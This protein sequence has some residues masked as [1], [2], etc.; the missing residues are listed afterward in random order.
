[1]I[2]VQLLDLSDTTDEL[3]RGGAATHHDE[4]GGNVVVKIDVVD[5]DRRALVL[6]FVSLIGLRS[7]NLFIKVLYTLGYVLLFYFGAQ[8]FLHF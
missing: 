7:R 3:Q 8:Y 2:T 4:A 5:V 6:I 1:M